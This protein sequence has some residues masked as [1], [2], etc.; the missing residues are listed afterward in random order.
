MGKLQPRAHQGPRSPRCRR[1]RG[2]PR[3][4]GTQAA[5]EA[6]RQS[7]TR[8]RELVQSANSAILR[9]SCDGTIT[10]LNEHAQQVFGWSADEAIGKP[11]DILVPEWESTGADLTGLVRNILEH[12][13][14]YVNVT[15]ENV[16][17]DGRRVWMS[18]TNRAIRDERDNVTE[19]LCIGNDVTE[20]KRRKRR[21]AAKSAADRHGAEMAALLDAVPVA[22]F[23]AHD[24][25]CLRMS[26]NRVTHELLGLPAT[27]N[28][29]KSAPPQQRPTNFRVMK[30]GRKIPADQ[31]PIQ[32]AARGQAVRDYD[33]DLVFAD[34]TVRTVRQCRAAARR[35]RPP[36]RGYRSV[37]RYHDAQAGRRGAKGERKVLSSAGG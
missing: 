37:R 15:N 23:I 25:E 14:R 9:W 2:L 19:I 24:A 21:S 3:D 6:L 22:V 20:R 27:A 18:W 5:E 11:V 33:F 35:K 4:H 12:P 36:A 10:F 32:M 29:S 8:Y 7:E 28:F 30:H 1:G 13:E 17:R 26:G 31:L 34:G 16:C